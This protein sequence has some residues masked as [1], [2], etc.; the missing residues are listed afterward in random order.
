HFQ[1]TSYARDIGMSI[2]RIAA[3]APAEYEAT[4]AN[5]IKRADSLSD[6]VFV[7]ALNHA[8]SSVR[9]AEHALRD[10]TALRVNAE[11]V[12]ISRTGTWSMG[13][14]ALALLVAAS[15]AWWL[16]RAISSPIQELKSG[17]AAVADG[18]L[19]HHV[20]IPVDRGDEFAELAESFRE[21][22]RQLSE[23][24]KLK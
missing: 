9:V 1:L 5:K 19:R 22:T 15:I 23:L 18:D 3:V 2:A 17:M 12:S 20:E 13:S 7:P 4:L 6:Q 11:T 16:T 8:D 21:M 10:R 24:D 14:L